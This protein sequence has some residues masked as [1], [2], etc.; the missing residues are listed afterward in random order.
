MMEH[1]GDGGGYSDYE[2]DAGARGG[3]EGAT[4]GARKVLIIARMGPFYPEEDFCVTTVN[5]ALRDLS[6]EV[7]DACQ[8]GSL[9]AAAPR[10]LTDN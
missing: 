4:P 1:E 8:R 2:E 3:H 9:T 5:G 6:V 7:I 10:L